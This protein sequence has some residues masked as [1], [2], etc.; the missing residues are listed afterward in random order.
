MIGGRGGEANSH[1]ALS[2]KQYADWL[3]LQ[4][5]APSLPSLAMT[6]QTDK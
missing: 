4:A 2:E 6:Q 1:H 5:P 3:I